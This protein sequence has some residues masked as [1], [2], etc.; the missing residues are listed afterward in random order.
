MFNDF[1]K[2]APV[3]II[4]IV[5]AIISIVMLKFFSTS[6]INYIQYPPRK[7]YLLATAFQEEAKKY[8]RKALE[9]AEEQKAQGKAADLK[10]DADLIHSKE[11]FLKSLDL[12]RGDEDVYQRLATLSELEHDRV[13]TY[14][15]Q[16]SAQFEA[17]YGTEGLVSLDKALSIAPG[18]EPSLEKKVQVLIELDRLEEA[19]TVLK[20]LLSINHQNATAYYL[21]GLISMLERDNISATGYFEKAVENNPRYLEA[22][23][24]LADI[25]AS[26]NDHKRAIGILLKIEPFYPTNASLK[27]AIGRFYFESGD[28]DPAYHYY[29]QAEKLE[30]NSASLYF[31]M[32]KVC[33]KMGKERLATIYL[34]RAM[35][36]DPKIKERVLFPQ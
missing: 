7:P 17:G 13:K 23:R 19:R 35:E 29:Q 25:V 18:D 27:H 31:D 12:I 20:E 10:G 33:T 6:L 14:Y 36:L 34:K 24:G 32:A 30:Q 16:A 15:Y 3:W 26:Q 8:Y 4:I 2:I 21:S 28:Y 11:L 22:A 5:I 1:K 9:K